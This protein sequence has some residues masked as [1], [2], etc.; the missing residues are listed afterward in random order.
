VATSTRAVYDA[1]YATGAEIARSSKEFT[2]GLISSDVERRVLDVG[3]G[4]GMNSERIA[5]SGHSVVGVDLSEEAIAKYRARGFEGQSCDIEEHLPFGDGE[6]D[7]AFCSEV[8]EHLVNPEVALR[9]IRRVLRPGGELVLSTPNSAFWL[10]RGASLAGRTV[11]ELQHPK[12]L[13]FFSKRGLVRLLESE[14]YRVDLAI[15]RNMYAILPDPRSR[16]AARVLA[17]LGF[18]QEKRF[19]TGKSFWH[20]SSFGPRFN[21]LFAD[22]LIVRAARAD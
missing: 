19:V 7:T 5:R 14:G 13:H 6:F 8:I 21:S 22:T 18:R 1:K 20:V 17:R 12:H 3:C 10:Y 2:L 16:L 4:T 9:E 11:S 15:G